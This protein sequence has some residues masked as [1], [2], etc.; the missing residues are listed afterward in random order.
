MNPFKG[1]SAKWNAN[2]HIEHLHP[3]RLFSFLQLQLK[4][5]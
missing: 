5:W 4:G 1:I 2:S 3:D